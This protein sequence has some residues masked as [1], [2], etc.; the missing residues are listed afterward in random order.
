MT[1]LSKP[2]N[3]PL[4]ARML[5]QRYLGASATDGSRLR[6]TDHEPKDTRRSQ[7]AMH[8]SYFSAPA[9]RCFN[10]PSGDF[11]TLDVRS[12]RLYPYDYPP[13]QRDRAV[14]VSSFQQAGTAGGK[15]ANVNS[16][17]SFEHAPAPPLQYHRKNSQIT[18]A[19]IMV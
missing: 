16:C 14:D 17:F 19:C 8:P 18:S 2:F 9:E 12:S 11:P 1:V 5:F 4:C 6:I 13:R 3:H 15:C 7:S 10:C